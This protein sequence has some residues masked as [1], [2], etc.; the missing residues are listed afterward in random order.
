[1]GQNERLYNKSGLSAR[2]EK[3]GPILPK[4]RVIIPINNIQQTNETLLSTFR[5]DDF[6][7]VNTN[8]D[9]DCSKKLKSIYVFR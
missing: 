1:M 2:T 4:K 7:V 5:G 8:E 9:Y 6:S 3:L